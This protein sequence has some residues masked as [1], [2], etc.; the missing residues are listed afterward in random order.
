MSTADRYHSKAAKVCPSCGHG[1][2]SVFYALQ[3][4]PVHS[5][6]L[7]R[8]REEA[9]GYPKGDI[10]LGLCPNCGFVSNLAFDPS[11]HEYSD[12]YEA[13]QGYSDT[14]NAF[15]LRLA[16]SLV[17][18]Y[19]L[20]EKRII[21]IGCG[22]GEFLS[23]LCE[24]GNNHGVGFDPAYAGRSSQ[25]A[26][27]RTEFVADFYTERY[28]GIPADFVCCKMTL[29]HI[30]DTAGF[31]R[32]VRKAVE[33]LEAPML[34][35]QVP[36]A[37]YV[38]GEMAFWDIYYEHCSYFSSGTL[39]RLFRGTGFEVLNLWTDYE[40]QYAMIEA[41]PSR[42]ETPVRADQALP[43]EET[44]AEFITTVEKFAPVVAERATLWRKR[45]EKLSSEGRK[46][47]LW[48][49]GSKAVALLTTLG[50]KTDELEYVVDINPYKAGTYIAGTGQEIVIP[51]RLEQI[52]PDSVVVM[53][54]IYKEEVRSLLRGM[55]LEPELI[56]ADE[57]Y[58]PEL[59]RA[60]N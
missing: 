46:V 60:G 50:I 51:G 2:M 54:P 31:M 21:E 39:A 29:E 26:S 27:G 23:L 10:V 32:T 30:Q 47:V 22:Q 43:M 19:D 58:L 15:H 33:G 56:G 6:L 41:R 4:V 53:N 38:F 49:G 57:M 7:L 13:T 3:Q 24:L 52:R 36:N 44:P 14:F 8:S 5:V 1:E 34:F 28:T 18:R 16:Q 59:G 11:L 45:A 9:A 12:Q 55:G 42:G 48:G 40:N 17:E 35:F 20:H 25:P 37:G